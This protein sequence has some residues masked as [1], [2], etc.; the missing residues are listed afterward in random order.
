MTHYAPPS[1]PPT[2]PHQRRHHRH[3]RHHH[4]HRRQRFLRTLPCL[5]GPYNG[6][7]VVSRT[8]L[9]ETLA[10][11]AV[12]LLTVTDFTAPVEVIK[13]RPCVVL[14]GRVHPG[15]T[16]A[17]W[18]MHGVVETLTGPSALAREL[19]SQLVIKIV[20]MLNP[21]GV[22]AGNHRCNLAGL[23]LNRAWPTPT[24][25][26]CP[27]ILHTKRLLQ[28]LRRERQL[29][30]F[31]DFHGHSRK[32]DIFMFGCEGPSGPQTGLA[33]HLFPRLCASRGENFN[34]DF[35]SFR[36]QKNKSSCARITVNKEVRLPQSYTL[37]ASFCGASQGPN[38]DYHFTVRDFEEMGLRVCQALWDRVS[39]AGKPRVSQMQREREVL[40][41]AR[42]KVSKKQ[43]EA[44][45]HQAQLAA[46]AAAASGAGG[47]GLDEFDGFGDGFEGWDD[48]GGGVGVG[49]G[50]GGG[51]MGGD[52]VAVLESSNSGGGGGGGTKKKKL[53]KGGSKRGKGRKSSKKA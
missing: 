45:Q 35:C 37:E 10:G 52:G 22:I 20:P 9:C 17:S 31:C 12:P 26:V 50:G 34:F 15:E 51:G 29:I 46:A 23:D 38:K 36:V 42:L 8:V 53:R 47:G 43:K 24:A 6:S 19:R 32:K 40:Y 16:N 30:L 41:P 5:E 28:H 27:T 13:Q 39:E 2:P 1:P 25:D 48:G 3:H 49:G 7:K 21:D 18:M 14:S 11:N 33:A 44:A 4:H